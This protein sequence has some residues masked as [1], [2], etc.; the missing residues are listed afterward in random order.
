MSAEYSFVFP[1][2][3]SVADTSNTVILQQQTA[4]S[5]NTPSHNQTFE[6][7]GAG[8]S[9]ALLTALVLKI[10]S[11]SRTPHDKEAHQNAALDYAGKKRRK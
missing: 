6:T 8:A 7:I 4:E 9:I 3:L 11:G 10:A 1:D 2:E 5:L